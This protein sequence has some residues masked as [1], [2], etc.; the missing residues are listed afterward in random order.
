MLSNLFVYFEYLEKCF[1]VLIFQ[2]LFDSLKLTYDCVNWSVDTTQCFICTSDVKL[3]VSQSKS[4]IK[5]HWLKPKQKT[6]EKK[7]WLKVSEI[8]L[9]SKLKWKP[10][11]SGLMEKT[12]IK[13]I[14]DFN[15]WFFEL[16]KHFKAFIIWKRLQNF[17]NLS[18][19]KS[20]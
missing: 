16:S 9:K 6:S 1:F 17:C 14:L 11:P 10:K 18:A 5:S 2:T 7:F 15:F 8:R 19:F 3:D 4:Q 13:T 12:V 20:E